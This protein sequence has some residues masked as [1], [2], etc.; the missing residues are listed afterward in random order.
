MT[1]IKENEN[2]WNKNVEKNRI[3]LNCVIRV[4]FVARRKQ[5]NHWLCVTC[6]RISATFL[7]GYYA[8][9]RSRTSVEK[10]HINERLSH[11][12]DTEKTSTGSR[13]FETKPSQYQCCSQIWSNHRFCSSNW[14][15]YEKKTWRFKNK[16]HIWQQSI[17]CAAC[18]ICNAIAHESYFILLN[19][20]KE[21]QSNSRKSFVWISFGDIRIHWPWNSLL[22]FF[23]YNFSTLIN[24]IDTFN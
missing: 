22:Y 7:F 18:F 16:I 1:K 9:W 13:I 2:L 11:N 20:W 21:I 6:N 8:I 17:P 19:F 23:L 10:Y 5:F 3:V 14:N 24:D 12:N 15:K 4:S